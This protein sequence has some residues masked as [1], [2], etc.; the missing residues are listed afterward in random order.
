VR[1]HE[2]FVTVR[3]NEV[4]SYQVAWH[5]HYVAWMEIGRNSLSRQFGL[6][7]DD[8]AGLSYM[9]PV[10]SLE[11]KYLRPARFNDEVRICTLFE[12]DEAAM[13]SFRCEMLA[14]D[15]ERLASGLVRHVLTDSCGVMQYRLPEE[16]DERVARMKAWLAGDAE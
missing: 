9:G 5:G 2:T 16:I 11:L 15:G 14:S 6:G 8:L 7:P 13:L 1:Y 10:V 3:F 12:G 4:D